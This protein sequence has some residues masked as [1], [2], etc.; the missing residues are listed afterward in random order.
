MLSSVV[1]PDLALVLRQHLGRDL[2]KD[3]YVKLWAS[4]LRWLAHAWKGIA[5]YERGSFYE[6]AD[7]QTEAWEHAREASRAGSKCTGGRAPQKAA[8]AA[9][10]RKLRSPP[11]RTCNPTSY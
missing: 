11:G 10:V 7:R 1:D 9:T 6:K 5:G 8:A 2:A 3:W 4:Q